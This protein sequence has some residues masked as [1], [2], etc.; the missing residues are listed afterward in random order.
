[1][2]VKLTI[3]YDG[4]NYH[5]WQIQ[6]NAETIQEILERALERILGVK[7]RIHG[8]GRTDAGV[9]A[10]G[11]VANFFCSDD[12]DLW[13]LQKGLNALTA[14]D[15]VIREARAVPD[16]FDP[17]R[18]ARSRVYEYR[19][20]NHPW[21]S[22]FCRR[23]SWHV[24]DPLA[25]NVMQEAIPCLEGEHDFTSFQAAGCEAAHPVRK[26]YRNSLIRQDQ[27]LIYTV[28][29]TAYLRHMVRNIVGTLVEIGRGE[30]GPQALSDLLG[31]R[32]RTLAGRTAP[33]E[34]LFLK[35]VKY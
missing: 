20:W 12:Q 21:P 3:E 19:I 2:N 17:R 6:P 24:R 28:E 29:A 4:T 30:R 23:F 22:A 1:M 34:G 9:H 5:G 8:S 32:D 35:E 14:Q 16:S 13:R 11:Q 26:I 25:L 31:V 7:T 27:F 33:A 15:I 18:D 10:L